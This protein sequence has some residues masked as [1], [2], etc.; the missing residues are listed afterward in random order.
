MKIAKL[1]NG[2]MK[3]NCYILSNKRNEAIII[4]PGLDKD[5][6]LSYIE[7]NKLKPMYVLLTHGHFDHIYSAKALKDNGAKIYITEV[8]GPKL[9]DSEINM[10]FILDIK[11]ELVIPDS[12]LKEGELELLGEKFEIFFTPG[13]TSGSCVIFYKNFAFTGDTFFETGVYGRTDLLDGNQEKLEESIKKLIPLL[14][15]K[16]VLAGHE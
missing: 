14:Q 10:G 3:Q 1:T 2:Q 12:F 7:K 8:D 9:L 5:G 6:I 16:K 4:D 15:N 13:H 11:T